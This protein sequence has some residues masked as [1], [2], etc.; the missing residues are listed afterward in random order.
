MPF[1]LAGSWCYVL[2][3]RVFL[4]FSVKC[5]SLSVCISDLEEEVKQMKNLL[6]RAES[7]KRQLQEELTD[8]EKVCVST[9]RHC[10]GNQG[11]L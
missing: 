1:P 6:S 2:R 9:L 11:A 10:R 4:H 5:L 7:E 8:L 3:A